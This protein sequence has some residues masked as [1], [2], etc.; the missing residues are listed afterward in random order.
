MALIFDDRQDGQPG[1][2]AILIGVG[3]YPFLQLGHKVVQYAPDSGL[4]QLESPLFS[5]EIFAQWLQTEMC[6]EGTPLRSLRVLG[7]SPTRPAVIQVTE[8]TF[9]GMESQVQEWFDDV[10][11]HPDNLAIFYFCGHGTKVGDVHALLAQDFG[12]NTYDPFQRALDADLFASA[13]RKA[14]AQ[15][16][17]FLIDS[18]SGPVPLPEYYESIRPPTIIAPSRNTNIAAGKQL[19]LRAS[20]LGT[21]AYG[22]QN[23]PSLFMDAFL[24]SMQG[25]AMIQS[26][27]KWVVHTELLKIALNWFIELRPEG[28]GQAVSSGGVGL[29]SALI[30]HEIQGSPIIPVKVSCDP[31]EFQ[32]F[33]ALHI[34][35]TQHCEAGSWPTKVHL[36]RGTHQFSAIE[37]DTNALQGDVEEIVH[38]PFVEISIPCG[39]TP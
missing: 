17:I 8:P 2:H 34:D 25:A 30:F 24:S 10:D 6:V 26:G 1:V 20:E 3:H 38:P 9:A 12:Q 16:Q 37:E 21:S 7:S 15:R 18:C 33:A 14:K 31:M 36:S 27:T 39:G 5:V 19:L 29:S 4:E 22:M 13:L 35:K 28:Q 23:G 32:S 11:Q